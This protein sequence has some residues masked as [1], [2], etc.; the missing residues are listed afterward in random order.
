M[1]E[2]NARR[3]RLRVPATVLDKQNYFLTVRMVTKDQS[4]RVSAQ[5]ESA[6]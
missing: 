4:I 2:F 5:A 1:A 6:P 3:K